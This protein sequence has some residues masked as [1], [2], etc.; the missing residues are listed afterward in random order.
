ME[1]PVFDIHTNTLHACRVL[2]ATNM[3]EEPNVKI[4]PY[5][6]NR[7]AIRRIPILAL[8]RTS[9]TNWHYNN[10]PIE[11]IELIRRLHN[12]L[13]DKRIEC[14]VV[15]VCALIPTTH[16]FAA[17]VDVGT[18]YYETKI[19]SVHGDDI[20]DQMTIDTKVPCVFL[21]IA[22]IRTD[23]RF[24]LANSLE[25]E[26]WLPPRNP[27]KEEAGKARIIAMHGFTDVWGIKPGETPDTLI[28][29][30]LH[31]VPSTESPFAFVLEFPE[32]SQDR[33]D[34]GFAQ[35]EDDN[36]SRAG[37]YTQMY[38]D[39]RY[40]RSRDSAFIICSTQYLYLAKTFAA[41]TFKWLVIAWG[42]VRFFYA[43]TSANNSQAY[44]IIPQTDA[45]SNWLKNCK[46]YT[47]N[48][49]ELDP[50]KPQT[51]QDA[52][53]DL[54]RRYQAS[55]EKDSQ[56]TTCIPI[57]SASVPGHNHG[58][59]DCFV[60]SIVQAIGRAED[61]Y[62]QTELANTLLF[63]LLNAPKHEKPAIWT[64]DSAASVYEKA[65]HDAFNENAREFG[66][67]LHGL[68]SYNLYGKKVYGTTFP[69]QNLAMLY[70]ENTR[71]RLEKLQSRM[72]RGQQLLPEDIM[73]SKLALLEWALATEKGNNN[74]TA[75]EVY[76]QDNLTDIAEKLQTYDTHGNKSLHWLDPNLSRRKEE[77]KEETFVNLRIDELRHFNAR[78]TPSS[79]YWLDMMQRYTLNLYQQTKTDANA[80]REASKKLH[81][82]CNW[83]EGMDSNQMGEP[84]SVWQ[85]ILAPE[86]LGWL[87]DNTRLP[88]RVP[89][90]FVD[91]TGFMT[92]TRESLKIQT[93]GSESKK[94]DKV[95]SPSLQRLVDR[96][97]ST[98]YARTHT[99]IKLNRHACSG[100]Y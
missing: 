98:Y 79:A 69:R 99:I 25:V 72:N 20:G 2:L 97:D 78:H 87:Y 24:G 5:R 32:Y 66:C 28:V 1:Q 80:A 62:G 13:F 3:E 53:L 61:Q 36:K 85:S 93:P 86:H 91:N 50:R 7:D 4:N 51:L 52:C 59:N 11:Y 63:S 42:R 48:P 90:R 89:S 81:Y 54:Y 83:R 17:R 43:G 88:F 41:F 19:L 70:Q 84:Q 71:H 55:E 40:I 56:P 27:T 57:A 29:D 39:E 64:D 46:F 96:Y 92:T 33:I 65:C 14:R 94:G 18:N 49:M 16:R 58:S 37:G 82:L 60:W 74:M 73:P 12:W 68:A 44:A 22:C 100:R 47:T 77:R 34:K 21:G 30:R 38:S 67:I 35:L 26:R 95:V 31:A 15:V 76:N 45:A 10:D 6:R 75:S 23:I 9:L 8:S